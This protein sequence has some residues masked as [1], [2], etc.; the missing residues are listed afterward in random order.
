MLAKLGNS[1]LADDLAKLHN[2]L[3]HGWTRPTVRARDICYRG[4]NSMRKRARAIGW[5]KS[6]W[7]SAG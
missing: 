2:W 3:Q 7:A 4:P 5:P 1:E 6:S